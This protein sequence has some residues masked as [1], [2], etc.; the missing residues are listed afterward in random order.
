M[1]KQPCKEFIE[2]YE[3]IRYSYI[4]WLRQ[5]NELVCYLDPKVVAGLQTDSPQHQ[6]PLLTLSHLNPPNATS[7]QTLT[8][9]LMLY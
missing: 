2:G 1:E 8:G 5:V 4:K 7:R 3:R 9:D 6:T